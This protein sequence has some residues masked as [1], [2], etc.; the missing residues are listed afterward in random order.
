MDS[1]YSRLI[2]RLTMSGDLAMKTQLRLLMR[3]SKRLENLEEIPILLE[4]FST[5]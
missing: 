1:Q 4:K 3:I 5:L 2:L